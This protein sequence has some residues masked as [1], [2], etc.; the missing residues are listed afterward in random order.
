MEVHKSQRDDRRRLRAWKKGKARA[1][2][3]ERRRESGRPVKR[4]K[5]N[6]RQRRE[7]WAVNNFRNQM[8]EVINKL[9]AEVNE[10]KA[11]LEGQT[12]TS[13]R[14]TAKELDIQGRSKMKKE[15][16]IDEILK[17]T[18]LQKK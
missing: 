8:T 4:R 7:V 11:E 16:L 5:L 15:E 2:S 18:T 6:L 1:A 9:I 3:L 17:R 14:E 12:V 10:K 13:L